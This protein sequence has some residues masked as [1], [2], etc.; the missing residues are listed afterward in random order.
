VTPL[1][2]RE[3]K[4]FLDA[5]P[6][7]MIVVD[8]QG[9]IVFANAQSEALFGYSR[10]ELVGQP[11]EYLLPERFRIRHLA[12]RAAYANAP[13]ARPMGAGF[14][15]YALRKDGTEFP[16]E[17]SLSPVEID[18]GRFVSSAIRDV[19]ERKA[20]ERELLAAR[21]A[22]E[23]SNREKSAFLA[24]ASHDLR[25]PLQTLSL[26]SGVL[27][28][29]VPGE[30]RAADAVASQSLALRSMGDLVN[31]LLDISKLEAGVIKPDIGN[32]AVQTIFD[33]LRGEFAALAAAK[34]LELIV[35]DCADTVRTDPALLSQIVQNLVGNA[36]RYTKEGWVRLQCLRAPDVVRIDV[37]DT[38]VGIPADD[39]HSIFDEFY[40]TRRF[41]ELG[42]DG[43]GLGLSIVRRLV[44][45]L[46]DT[47]EV[48][49]EVG[50]GSR[51]SV[52]VPRASA[53]QPRFVDPPPNRGAEKATT[54][55]VLVIDDEPAVAD[56]TAL[57]LGVS[58]FEVVVATDAA[59]A[60]ERL[61]ELGR[62]P[63][64]VLCDFRL[65]R[66]DNGVD[67]IR[68]IR[69]ATHPAL[70]AILVTGDISH[71]VRA[72]LDTIDNCEGLAK[73]VDADRLLELV[74]RLLR[75]SDRSPLTA[76]T[77]MRR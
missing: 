58:G 26:L 64:L 5:S 28:R 40:Q 3:V 23:R 65:R 44:N 2:E 75:H 47:I 55:I 43:V 36:I 17:I 12:H 6:D 16:A 54:G 39:L 15:L 69:A 35:E 59:Q 31:S 45:L 48:E 50:V 24:A 57:F 8:A 56:A 33:R 18:R 70:P 52:N 66:G 1:P 51:F 14:E 11:L 60:M 21:E 74:T 76:L 25:Q 68:A 61:H 22:A 53:Q 77:A 73:P 19:T 29:A 27:S 72:A 49:S 42:R 4:Q 20:I 32:C 46:G 67:A 10:A 62:A 9:A 41:P 13:R 71:A 38:G 63:D 7:A 30:S 37:L 34:G